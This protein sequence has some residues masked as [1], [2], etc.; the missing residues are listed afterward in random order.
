MAVSLLSRAGMEL[1][2]GRPF[3]PD[4]TRW[5]EHRGGRLLQP[6]RES[7]AQWIWIAFVLVQALDGGMT[8][9]GIHMFGPPI[10][11]NPLVAWYVSAM[12]PAFA[13]CAAKLFAVGCGITLYLAARHRTLAAL[14]L[15]YVVAAVGPWVHLFWRHW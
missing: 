11:A 8:F 12:G 10:E 5:S 2:G 1:V 7:A 15:T 9:V 6:A 3:L 4:V 13:L 14:A